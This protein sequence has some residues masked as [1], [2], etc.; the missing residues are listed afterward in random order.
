MTRF[1]DFAAHDIHGISQPMSQY[2]GKVVLIVNTASACGF[3]PQ[4]AGLQQL[5]QQYAPQGLV[6]L[7]FPCNQFGQQDKGD[8]A[9]IATFCQ[10][11]Y[12]VD[13]PMMAKA[14]VNGPHALPLFAWL[15]AQA[16]GLLGTQMIKW[17]FTKFL[18]GRDGLVLQ[19]FAPKTAPQ[20]IA[21]AIENALSATHA[22][23]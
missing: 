4:L 9:S 22:Q 3:T 19:R 18:L 13:F 1:Y 8:N 15:K 2:A 12:G 7:G 10:R 6:V 21:S 16:P 23:P 5:H 17:N 14:E 20:H 11:N